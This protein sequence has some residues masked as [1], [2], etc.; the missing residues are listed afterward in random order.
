MAC[1]GLVK[2]AGYRQYACC[3][4]FATNDSL[5]CAPH[6][7]LSSV[8]LKRRWVD[9]YLGNAIY[10]YR[11][12]MGA[13]YRHRGEM[14]AEH[15]FAPLRA[16]LFTL[17]QQDIKKIN[18]LPH[19]QSVIDIYLLLLRDGFCTPE[20]NIKAFLRLVQFYLTLRSVR[21]ETHYLWTLTFEVLFNT[22][23]ALYEKSLDVILSMTN[24]K[25]N[26]TIKAYALHP[27][28][29]VLLRDVL[30]TD[31]GHEWSWTSPKARYEE[32]FSKEPTPA[33]EMIEFMRTTFFP[34]VKEIYIEEKEVQKMRMDH[35]KEQLMMVCWHPDRV[36]Y[37]LEMGYEMDDI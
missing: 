21:A 36:M 27:E 35:C 2:R 32:F 37:Y 33:P 6:Q 5:F 15:A 22:S 29:Q 18:I 8:E 16:G 25:A 30:E 1:L 20:D 11:G 26:A 3:R 4:N 13:I 17:T 34:R 12:E 10:R 7:T 28:T 31:I 24:Q 9:A 19:N 14:G 23:V